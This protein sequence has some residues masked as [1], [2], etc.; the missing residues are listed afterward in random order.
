MTL[1]RSPSIPYWIPNEKAQQ[2]RYP[3]RRLTEG[4]VSREDAV[5]RPLAQS[6]ERIHGKEIVEAI[7]LVP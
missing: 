4:F 2:L 7:L 6:V 5:T 1:D 3:D